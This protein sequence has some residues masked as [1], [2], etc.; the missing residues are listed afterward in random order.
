MFVADK[1]HPDKKTI[2]PVLKQFTKP[3]MGGVFPEIIADGERRE[4]GF[5][6]LPLFNKLN[7]V[8]VDLSLDVSEIKKSIHTHA[9]Q[10]AVKNV[11]LFCITD[12]LTS[13]KTTMIDLLYDSWGPEANYVGA[14]AGSLSFK[15][16]PCI[17]HQ[18][19]MVGNAAVIGVIDVTV[20][21]GVAHGWAPVSEAIKVTE[22]EGN[23]II[24]LNWEPAFDVYREQILRHSGVEISPENFF[25][26]AKSYPLGLIRLDSE[27]TIRD[28]YA[29]NNGWLHIVDNVPEGD[30]I[31][32]MNGNI[33]SLLEGASKAFKDSHANISD[34]TSQQFCVDCISRVLYMQDE[35]DRELA[36]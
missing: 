22:T 30:Y 17:I 7:T 29:T 12:A 11:S 16:L 24:S 19:T 32:I 23:S 5:L 1:G 21:I 34:E 15:P 2:E 36:L 28:P 6:V 14:G 26:V 4:T 35:F 31:R 13:E 25:D 33:N 20:N 8:L 27:M 9:Q 3:L 10:E 18:H